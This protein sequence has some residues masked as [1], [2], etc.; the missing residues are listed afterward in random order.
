MWKEIP[1]SMPGSSQYW[2]WYY[3][4]KTVIVSTM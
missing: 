2:H 3:S 1:A 4:K